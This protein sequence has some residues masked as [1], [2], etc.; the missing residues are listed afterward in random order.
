MTAELA[1]LVVAAFVVAALVWNARLVREM[2]AR[3]GRSRPLWAAAGLADAP[4]ALLLLKLL[5]RR[6]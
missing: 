6:R 4:L 2:A 5:G 3:R 1:A